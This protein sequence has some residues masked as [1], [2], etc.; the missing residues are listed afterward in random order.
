[1]VRQPLAHRIATDD[2]LNSVT[3]YLPRFDREALTKIKDELEGK[4][5]ENGE[6]KVGPDVLREPKTFGRNKKIP[7]EVF[8]FIETLPSIPIPD[9][10]ANPLR[11]G[12]NLVRLLAD[13]RSGRALLE[14]ADAVL[15]RTI[16]ARM[17]GLA[18]EHA[19]QVSSIVA[20]IKNVEVQRSKLTP[21]GHYAGESSRHI[22]TH[23]KDI[24]H[25]TRKII[26]TLKEG[27]GTSYYAHRVRNLDP[28]INKLDVRIEVAAMLKVPGVIAEIEATANKFVQGQLV[29][30][31]VEI[32]NTTGAIR[33]AYRKVQEQTPVLEPSAL[34]L[35]VN[36]TAATKSVRGE[37]LPT[38][39]RH[40][41]SDPDDQFPVQLNDWE[42]R[43]I[44]IEIARPSFVAWYR[45]PQ[46]AMPNSLRIPYQD[47]SDKWSSLQIDFLIISRR[48]NGQL[49]ASIVDPH[50]DHLADAKAK[51]RALANF[52][53]TYGRHFL[54][55]QSISKAA[56][57][58]LHVLD[59]LEPQIRK[60]VRE[61]E[62][63]KVSPLY[64]SEYAML[65]K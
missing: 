20:D 52:A 13:N 62:G 45:N 37:G 59:L 25:D 32:K 48:D 5:V 17:D 40:I 41:Y 11:R 18:A 22:E 27:A 60:A 33:D 58:E 30:Y 26:N 14:D 24:D 47:E 23:I 3:C 31:A 16:N 38:Y 36:E 28:T 64:T 63:G 46:R 7:P 65:Y 42:A 43:V 21:T 34:E 44:A 54:R 10:F 39:K 8:E 35:R 51:L 15:T 1:M 49:A 57:G 6:N 2:S 56:D 19:D 4:G 9:K 55:I 12:K 53:E 50:G 29:K 61:F